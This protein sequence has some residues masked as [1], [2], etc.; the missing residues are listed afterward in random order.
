M[1]K[2]SDPAGQLFPAQ[3][4]PRRRWIG[5]KAPG[6]EKFWLSFRASSVG[7]ELPVGTSACA[8]PVTGEGRVLE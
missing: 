4:G 5:A 1:T 7:I 3:L 2:K 6:G 8:A